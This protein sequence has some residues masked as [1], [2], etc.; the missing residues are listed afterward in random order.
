MLRSNC[1]VYIHGHSAGGT[2]PSLVEAMYLGLPIIAFDVIYNQVTTEF[3]A[4]YFK[5]KS[6]LLAQVLSLSAVDLKE[7]GLEMKRIADRRYTWAYISNKYQTSF[8]GKV[9]RPT[10]PIL[11]DLAKVAIVN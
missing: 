9:K 11:V 5:T 10:P 3:N 1:A 4:A 7:F 8:I 2:N 6:D